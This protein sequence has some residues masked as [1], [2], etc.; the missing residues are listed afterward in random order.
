MR[1]QCFS[2]RRQLT[3]CISLRRLSLTPP[4]SLCFFCCPTDDDVRATQ[5]G[6]ERTNSAAAAD[7]LAVSTV[8][9][10]SSLPAQPTTGAATTPV[11]DSTAASPA[12]GVSES[13]VATPSSSAPTT[14]RPPRVPVGSTQTGQVSSASSEASWLQST[15]YQALFTLVELFHR[16]QVSVNFLL[17]EL[18]SLICSCIDGDSDELAKIGLRC[19]V[20]LCSKCGPQLSVQSWWL[21]LDHAQDTLDRLLPKQLT[22]NDTRRMLGLQ[23]ISAAHTARK[24]SRAQPEMLA[25]GVISVDSETPSTT[26][27]T[28]TDNSTAS[29]NSTPTPPVDTAATSDVSHGPSILPPASSTTAT[30]SSPASFSLPL[31][32]ASIAVRSRTSLLMMD[33]LCEVVLAYFPRRPRESE[34]LPEIAQPVNGSSDLRDFVNPLHSPIHTRESIAAAGGVV[35]QH[36][37]GRFDYIN[38]AA[39]GN[40]AEVAESSSLV[41]SSSV[42]VKRPADRRVLGRL[43][44][45]QLFFC[46]DILHSSLSF[47]HYFNADLALRKALHTAGLILF[48]RPNRLPQLFAQEAHALKVNVLLLFTM[49]KAGIDQRPDVLQVDRGSVEQPPSFLAE[50]GTASASPATKLPHLSVTTAALSPASSAATSAAQRAVDMVDFDRSC[51]ES[52]QRLFN[53]IAVCFAVYSSKARSMQLSALE[54]SD[55]VLIAFIEQYATLPSEHFLLHFR[56]VWPHVVDLIEY[57]QSAAL[58]AAVRAFFKGPVQSMFVQSKLTP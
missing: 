14:S 36:Q 51:W 39:A 38:T 28:V 18:L 24:G 43:T 16:F 57:A 35:S 3:H 30:A 34:P 33:S 21:V 17:P 48:D 55:E 41:A 23:P 58:R 20:A 10:S 4:R 12:P 8:T 31:T 53:L 25:A 26:A 37:G 1:H 13:A 2:L 46:L 6:R 29:T 44:C 32:S 19:L 9:P 15:C 40:T 50:D 56:Q 49:Y 52:E 54:H 42:S 27:S 7:Q 22:S 11:A 5:A 45:A 47:T